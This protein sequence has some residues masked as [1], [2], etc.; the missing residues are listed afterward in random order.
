MVTYFVENIQIKR[1]EWQLIVLTI[2]NTQLFE[3]DYTFS[4]DFFVELF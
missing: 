1:T 2:E 3:C 4:A